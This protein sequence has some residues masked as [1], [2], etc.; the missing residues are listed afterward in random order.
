MNLSEED[1]AF[2]ELAFELALKPFKEKW[3][4]LTVVYNKRVKVF[5]DDTQ[6][7]VSFTD[8][9]TNVKCGFYAHNK[10]VVIVTLTEL[11][12]TEAKFLPNLD[13]ERTLN[14]LSCTELEDLKS[15]NDP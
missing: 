4:D 2:E 9:S 3:P 14:D 1:A 6:Y 15:S 8:L 13:Q 12:R 7:E 11:M 5:W 10:R